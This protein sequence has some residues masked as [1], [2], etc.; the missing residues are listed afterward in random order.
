[1]SRVYWQ[2]HQERTVLYLVIFHYFEQFLLEY[3]NRFERHNGYQRPIVQ[4]VV[5]KYLD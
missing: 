3:E 4:E 2:H 1:M 5:E